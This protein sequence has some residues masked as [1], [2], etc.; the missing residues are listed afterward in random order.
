MPGR[1]AQKGGSK[2]LISDYASL[3]EEDLR[4][5]R[6]LIFK[7]QTS[8][9][10]VERVLYLVKQEMGDDM[11]IGRLRALLAPLLRALVYLR[12]HKDLDLTPYVFCQ[13]LSLDNVECLMRNSS[14][15]EDLSEAVRSYLHS[16]PGYVPGLPADK[17]RS[18]TQ[19]LHG[20]AQMSISKVLRDEYLLSNRY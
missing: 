19:D 5:S 11:W 16:I 3:E 17:Q 15:P 7:S 1:L 8:E 18:N 2:V 12:D 13:N 10:L 9:E 6:S 20:F 4:I 14:L